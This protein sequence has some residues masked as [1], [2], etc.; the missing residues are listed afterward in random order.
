MTVMERVL[1][2]R[3]R[4][5]VCRNRINRFDRELRD[6]HESSRKKVIMI[7][8]REMEWREADRS[9]IASTTREHNGIL[10]NFHLGREHIIEEEGFDRERRTSRIYTRLIDCS[11]ASNRKFAS[12][13]QKAT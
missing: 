5:G 10:R 8:F 9:F 3:Q 2:R 7:P 4:S 11:L 1:S 12:F 6:I 13:K